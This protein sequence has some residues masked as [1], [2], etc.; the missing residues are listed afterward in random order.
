LPGT[1]TGIVIAPENIIAALSAANANV[2]LASGNVGQAMVTACIEDGRILEFCQQV[3]RPFYRER[4]E[5]AMIWVNDY[6]DADLPW[7]LHK[8]EGAMFLWLWCRDMPISAAVLY[9]R[10]KTR[11]VLVVPGHHFFYGMHDGWSHRQECIRINFSQPDK[12]V[13]EGL[14]IM[15]QE[16]STAYAS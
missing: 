16:I 3:V 15:S 7:R 5:Q 13:R 2:S 4:F 6:F 9:E 14:R 10:L 12:V 8:W 11:G 1:R